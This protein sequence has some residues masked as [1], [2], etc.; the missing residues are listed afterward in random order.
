MNTLTKLV[1]LCVASFMTETATASNNCTLDCQ[2]DGVCVQEWHTS[3]RS[4]SSFVQAMACQCQDGFVGPLCDTDVNQAPDGAV[5]EEECSLDCANGGACLRQWTSTGPHTFDK[6]MICDCP[7]GFGG[8]LCQNDKTPPTVASNET[9]ECTKECINGECDIEWTSYSMSNHKF[10]SNP[11]CKC[12]AGFEGDV[13]QYEVVEAA[14]SSLSCAHTC[15]NG[16]VC[17]SKW[18]TAPQ[19][20]DAMLQ[21]SGCECAPGFTGPSCEIGVDEG[22]TENK[23][24][25]DC[26]NGGECVFTWMDTGTHNT[27]YFNSVYLSSFMMCECPARYM[28]LHCEY[29]VETCPDNSMCFNGG[30]CMADAEDSESYTCDCGNVTDHEGSMCEQKKEVEVCDYN[31]VDHGRT[32]FCVNGGTCEKVSSSQQDSESYHHGCDCLGGFF[33]HHC[34]FMLEAAIARETTSTL[35]GATAEA[36]S[37]GQPSATKVAMTVVFAFGGVLLAALM[38]VRALIRDTAGVDMSGSKS[39]AVVPST[40]AL[41]ADGTVVAEHQRDIEGADMHTSVSARQTEV[42]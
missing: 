29:Q 20:N 5:E 33:G 31:H 42:V 39:K 23:C 17:V 37:S 7:A 41:D 24:H 8:N 40:L 10:V 12:D 9:M 19:A 36:A 15:H 38:A 13:C 1:T 2:N 35:D 22:S 30:E 14:A 3:A 32:L 26:Q 21:L 11:V 34:E 25:L 6:Q 27:N 4:T 18:E 28:G 16:G